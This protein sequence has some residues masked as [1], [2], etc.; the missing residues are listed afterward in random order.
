MSTTDSDGNVYYDEGDTNIVG[1]FGDELFSNDP[2]ADGSGGFGA[3]I[4]DYVAMGV[5]NGSFPL[6]PG[7]GLSTPIGSNN[8]M[9]YWSGLHVVSGSSISAT[10]ERDSSGSDYNLR[11]TMAAGAAGDEA[12]V[13]QI[14]RIPHSKAYTVVPA[15]ITY[16]PAALLG[17]AGSALAY[18]SAQYLQ[19]DGSTTT[20]GAKTT[21]STLTAINA[22]TNND[23]TLRAA[24]VNT[25]GVVPLD[26]AFIRV[27]LGL[28]RDVAATSAAGSVDFTDAR[29]LVGDIAQYFTD[30]TDPA[31][32]GAGR[33]IQSDGAFWVRPAFATH[34]DRPYLLLQTSPARAFLYGG[35]TGAAPYI[36]VDATSGDITLQPDTSLGS[37]TLPEQTAP[38]APTSGYYAIYPKTDG[39]LYGK[40]DAG[41]EVAFSGGGGATVT[42]RTSGTADWTPDAASTVVRVLMW[43]A[44]GGGASGV[45]GGN[46]QVRAGGGGG[47]G[48]SFVVKD[49]QISA[50]TTPVSVAVGAGGTG[51]A[52]V[53][54][55]ASAGNDGVVG[56]NTTFGTYLTAYGGGQGLGPALAIVAETGGSGAGTAEVGAIGATGTTNTGGLPASTAGADGIAGQGGGSNSASAGS[57]AEYGGGAGGGHTNAAN[58]DQ[59]GGT[60]LWGGGG[61]GAGGNGGISQNAGSDGGNTAVYVVAGGGGGAGGAVRTNGTAGTSGAGKKGGTGGGGGGGSSS[62]TVDAGDGGAGGLYGGGG[63][64]GGAGTSGTSAFSGKGGAGGN[65]AC[66][67]VE[68]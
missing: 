1:P 13:E 18:I 67:I 65:G 48:G 59:T 10:W 33:L 27:R 5:L 8:T 11:F 68:W 46:G 41:T 19:V 55:A 22:A 20:G 2:A 32:Y 56:G 52:K 23:L 4:V 63:G 3:P 50:L 35:P 6:G 9:P 54:T 12:Y 26:A 47:G 38:G 45:C 49:F 40:N 25:T 51:G 15:T 30:D 7:L 24:F 53:G 64:G 34:T 36:Q 16:C 60:S 17:T 57:A 37:M 44:G 28:G 43:G 62:A 29:L 58:G 31:T 66:I 42:V 61:G 39:I 14:V 21:T